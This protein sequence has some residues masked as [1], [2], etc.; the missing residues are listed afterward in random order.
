MTTDRPAEQGPKTPGA[1]RLPGGVAVVTGERLVTVWL[2]RPEVRNA[3]TFRTWASLAEVAG[4]LPPR[5]QVVL[6]RATGRDFSAGLDLRQLR[7]GGTDEGSVTELLAGDDASVEGAIATFQHAFGVWRELPAVVVAVVQGRAI[8]AGA[9]LALAADLRV[10][11]ADA[12]LVVA[13]SRLGLVPDL[14]GT[15]RLVELAGYAAALE[16]TLTARPVG[17]EEALR[18]GLVTRLAGAEGLDGCVAE[19]VQELLALP[20]AVSRATKQLVA[21]ATGRST[22][23][24]LAAE[25]S[26]QVPLLRRLAQ[27]LAGPGGA[28]PPAQE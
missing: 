7:P 11:A 26:A 16:L 19:L 5:C 22:D 4:T 15:A 24:Q 17:A 10:L 12:E 18:L 8:G 21:G 23:A 27:P 28:A 9:Q 13:E 25:R 20:A 1:R 6:L 3:Q 2:D 14:G